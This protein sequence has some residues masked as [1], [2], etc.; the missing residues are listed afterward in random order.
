MRSTDYDFSTRAIH[1]GYDP[2]S[3][4]GALNPPVYMSSTFTFDTA[5]SGG[6]MFAG[7]KEG[8]F[9]S[10]I[11]N[12]T[13]DHLEQRIA[14]LEGGAAGLCTASGMGAITSTLWSFLEAGDEVIID[15]TLYGCTFAFMTHG[16]PRFGVKV[17]LVDMTN[18]ENLT[19]AIS[20][21][22]KIVY[23][24]TPANPN[25]RL[26]D[27]AAV[28]RIA[29][30]AGAKV[31]VDNTYATPVITRPLEHGADIV[32]HSATKF[33]SG[34]GDVV[35]GLI[36]GSL[37]D[38]T[39]IRLVGLKDM[40]GAV[41]SPMT[42]MLLLRGIKTLELRMER[43]CKTAAEVAQAL[44]AHPAVLSVS[45]PGLDSFAQRDLARRQMASFGGMIPFEVKGG[46]AGG[47]AL[48]NR[49]NLIQRAVSLGDAES[50]IQHPASM[51]H[52]TYT[53]EERAEHGIAEGLV[54]LS[55]GL[56]GAADLINDLHAALGAHNMQAA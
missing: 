18:P 29:H 42:A 10:R 23:F 44:E 13:L 6:A 39:Q 34:H 50:L 32:L 3:H 41:M 52:S 31:V 22:T 51:T 7:E 19:H 15:K 45:Y 12:P 14:N 47:I 49:L 27:I 35:A 54:R 1:H 46:K 48:M 26:V 37:E 20:A 24:E 8:H 33:L 9:Y 30:R 4:Q 38:I 5:E 25:N 43:H 21:K 11:S 2:Q 40:T 55:V 28:S 53:P 16:L 56:E 17:T 36:V